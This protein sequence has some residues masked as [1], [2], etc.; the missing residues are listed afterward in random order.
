M[1]LLLLYRPS[2]G[3]WNDTGRGPHDLDFLGG[4]RKRK[5]KKKASELWRE[6]QKKKRDDEEEWLVRL[7]ENIDEFFDDD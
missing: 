7:M 4:P 6:K 2:N 3:W 1:S 5:K